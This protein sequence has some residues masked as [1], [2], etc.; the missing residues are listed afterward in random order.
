MFQ[1]ARVP[2]LDLHVPRASPHVPPLPV[3]PQGLLHDGM[4]VLELTGPGGSA[5]QDPIV[6]TENLGETASGAESCTC[7]V[8]AYYV[9][10]MA[11]EHHHITLHH[12]PC[13]T[14]CLSCPVPRPLDQPAYC[15]PPLSNTPPPL[16]L[17]TLPPSPCRPPPTPHPHPHPHTHPHPQ[18]WVRCRSSRSAARPTTPVHTA[19]TPH[20]AGSTSRSARSCSHAAH[21]CRTGG[22]WGGMGSTGSARGVCGGGGVQAHVRP[23]VGHGMK[24][25]CAYL[26]VCKAYKALIT[27]CCQHM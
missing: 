25:N 13:S 5:D 11:C 23:Q 22:C 7:W 10:E 2:P 6:T 12:A 9:A 15:P 24:D 3:S 8:C 26:E 17:H 14:A 1:C 16:T 27:G 19:A 4:K 20:P 21:P 18:V